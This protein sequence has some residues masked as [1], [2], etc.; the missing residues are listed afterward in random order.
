VYVKSFIGAISLS[1]RGERTVFLSPSG[2][3]SG[4]EN[5]KVT[6][7]GL[8]GVQTSDSSTLAITDVG[9]TSAN[10]LFGSTAG[11]TKTSGM[12]VLTV[13]AGQT[14]G[15]GQGV[16][17]SF[18]VTNPAP[19]TSPVPILV[20]AS[21]SRV[22]GPERM[23]VQDR[24]APS[25]ASTT[26][27][28]DVHTCA[29]FS[30]HVASATGIAVGTVLQIDDELMYVSALAGTHVTVTRANDG[31]R[32]AWHKTGTTIY[33]IKDGCSIGFCVYLSFLL[34]LPWV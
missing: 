2:Y 9:S 5:S 8:I 19:K 13:A 34:S 23:M 21:G 28:Q 1:T 32:P 25:T 6:I 7:E 12:L 26:L 14:L 10:V 31:T 33:L 4:A 27:S 29:N 24:I 11:W 18:Q 15:A 30:V 22:L 17:F 16:S 20:S 3:L